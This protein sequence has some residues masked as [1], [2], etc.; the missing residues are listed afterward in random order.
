MLSRI[1]GPPGPVQRGDLV[2]LGG[3]LHCQNLLAVL[4]KNAMHHPALLQDGAEWQQ[5]FFNADA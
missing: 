5:V 2:G 4:L 3:P 1:A